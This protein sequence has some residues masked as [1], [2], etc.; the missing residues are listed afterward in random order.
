MSPSDTAEVIQI[1]PPDVTALVQ[2]LSPIVQA[3]QALQVVDVES[4]AMAQRYAA[5]LRNGER[6]FEAEFKDA[7]DL[8]NRAHKSLCATIARLVAPHAAARGILEGK[9]RRFRQEQERKAEEERLRLQEIARREEEERQLA[10]A[11]E[12]EAQGDV[13]QAEAIL[14]EPVSVPAVQVKPEVAQVEGISERQ[15]WKARVVDLPALQRFVGENP[16]WSHLTEAVMPQLNALA[17]AQ[18]DNLRIP[19]VE[20]YNDPTRSYKS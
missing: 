9:S 20:A 18:R 1:R 2:E 4:D 12:A 17:R 5:Q 13:A 6:R 10:A 3:A 11:L 15:N 7:K 19:G 8:A 14:E 16:Q